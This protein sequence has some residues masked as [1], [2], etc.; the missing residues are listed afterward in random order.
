ME[1]ILFKNVSHKII[2]SIWER[3]ACQV[4]KNSKLIACPYCAEEIRPEAVF[5]R[6]CQ[7]DVLPQPKVAK[8]RHG[9]Q[10][11]SE[12]SNSVLDSD[13]Q[14]M[15]LPK[16]LKSS[17]TT[18]FAE[19]GSDPTLEGTK[20]F[21]VALWLSFFLGLIGVDRF[22]LGYVKAGCLKLFTAGVF[23]IFWIRDIIRIFRGLEKDSLGYNLRGYSREA[24]NRTFGWVVAT[25]IVLFPI[26][27]SLPREEPEKTPTISVQTNSNLT[28]E[29]CSRIGYQIGEIRKALMKRD[30]VEKLTDE[31][32]VASI[33]WEQE[34]VIYSGSEKDWLNK[35]AELAKDLNSYLWT[36]S[37]WNGDLILSQLQN[38]MNLYTQFCY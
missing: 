21:R 8:K 37:P 6:F 31:L 19:N 25:S 30:S 36:G 4:T 27:V 11:V 32:A 35:M 18:N 26:G 5:C 12:S 14:Y 1:W 22:Y 16:Q 20:S 28:A 10:V 38:N 33:I 24:R 15:G 7:K 34:G 23:G 29:T 3:L 17:H 2:M 13:I 9:V